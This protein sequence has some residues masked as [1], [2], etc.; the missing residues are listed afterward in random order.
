MRPLTK[1]S[2]TANWLRG[3]PKNQLESEIMTAVPPITA[4]FTGADIVLLP[5]STFLEVEEG[6]TCLTMIPTTLELAIWGNLS[7]MD[8][9]IGYDLVKQEVTKGW[10]VD[11]WW[12]GVKTVEGEGCAGF[13][14]MEVHGRLG[15]GGFVVLLVGMA[16]GL[17]R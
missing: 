11:L 17:R 3:K 13:E 9:L 1:S 7:Q 2:T 10:T 12:A 6:I 16:A 15:S 5:T 8:F 14:V 4:H